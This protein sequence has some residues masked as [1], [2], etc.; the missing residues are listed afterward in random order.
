MIYDEICAPVAI[1]RKRAEALEAERVQE[2]RS[3]GNMDTNDADGAT[4]KIGVCEQENPFAHEIVS[5]SSADVR[6]SL[7]LLSGDSTSADS[8]GGSGQSNDATAARA[9]WHE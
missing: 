8:I 6:P 1:Q 3:K 7:K 9:K 5:P 2:M 4:D